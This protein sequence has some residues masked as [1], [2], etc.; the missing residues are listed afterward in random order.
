MLDHLCTLGPGSSV[1][2][3]QA[4]SAADI[5]YL[6]A[7][8]L[9]RT[10]KGLRETMVGTKQKGTLARNSDGGLKR[11]ELAARTTGQQETDGDT[12]KKT[13]DESKVQSWDALSGATGLAILKQIGC[14]RSR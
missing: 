14:A 4:K 7:S 3:Q 2:M 1:I 12:K 5:R 8:A 9:A 13:T 10:K 6:S 11:Y